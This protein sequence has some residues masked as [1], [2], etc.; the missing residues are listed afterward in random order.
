MHGVCM[1]ERHQLLEPSL[2]QTQHVIQQPLSAVPMQHTAP[3]ADLPAAGH[4]GPAEP[5]VHAAGARCAAA[6]SNWQ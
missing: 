5:G 4:A 6:R 3:A 2:W 1:R